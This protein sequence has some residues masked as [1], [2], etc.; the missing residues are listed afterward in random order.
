[1]FFPALDW[2]HI[3]PFLQLEKAAKQ[4]LSWTDCSTCM[5]GGLLTTSQTNSSVEEFKAC[6]TALIACPIQRRGLQRRRPQNW[7][8]VSNEPHPMTSV[9]CC[10][11]QFGL[12]TRRSRL[13]SAVSPQALPG[14]VSWPGGRYLCA[15]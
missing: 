12:R 4:T 10:W 2:T 9:S 6:I 11:H 8:F 13:G 15:C 5:L 7:A 1:M 14:Y 3:V